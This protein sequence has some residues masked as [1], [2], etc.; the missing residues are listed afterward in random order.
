M[1]NQLIIKAEAGVDQKVPP[2]DKNAYDRIVLAGMKVL[3][4]KNTH[5][6]IMQGVKEAQDKVTTAADGIVGLM[7]MLH[8]ESRGT[9]PVGPMILAGMSLL[10]QAL[11]FMEQAGMV[12]V[13]NAVLDTATQH[14][15]ET[16]LPKIGM[17]PEKIQAMLGQAQGIMADPE[18]MAQYKQSMEA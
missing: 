14:Y 15:I 12:Q 13:D 4:S 18:K 7:G 17:T 10:M 6:Q 16:L 3:F 2:K 8:K 1:Q 11:D 5:S 9:M